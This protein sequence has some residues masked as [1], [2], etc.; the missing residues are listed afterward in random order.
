MNSVTFKCE[1]VTPM[2]LAGADGIEPD[3][4]PPSIKG[5]MRFWWR[6]LHGYMDVKTL[7]EKEVEVFGGGGDSAKR[8]RLII[9]TSHPK[10]DGVYEAPMLP[11]KPHK[12][13]QVWKEAYKPENTVFD[14]QFRISHGDRE[15]DLEKFRSFFI[16]TLLLGGFGK[17]SR[18]GFGSVKITGIKSNDQDYLEAL[19]MPK[20]LD[21]I[22]CFISLFNADYK[23]GHNYAALKISLNKS[24]Y[25]ERQYPYIEKIQIGNSAYADYSSLLYKVGEATHDFKDNDPSLGYAETQNRFASPVFV[26]AIKYGINDYR[27]IITTLHM[28]EKNKKPVNWQKQEDFINAIL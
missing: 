8:S 10:W 19:D 3:L 26:S 4:R 28:A 12:R 14:V 15:F 7:R 2:F 6:A 1:V 18:R 16:L 27:A 9:K 23:I 24:A 21:E 17:R 25:P 11:H 5:A 20:T 13:D 22:L